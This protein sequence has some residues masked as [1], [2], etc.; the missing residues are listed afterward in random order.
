MKLDLDLD[1]G[2]EKMGELVSEIWNPRALDLVHRIISASEK[3][4]AVITGFAED[5]EGVIHAKSVRFVD[6]NIKGVKVDLT[7][8]LTV[9]SRFAIFLSESLFLDLSRTRPAMSKL[10]CSYVS[11]CGESSYG[12]A[13]YDIPTHAVAGADEEDGDST[14]WMPT[15]EQVAK[16]KAAQAQ[17]AADERMVGMPWLTVPPND[18]EVIKAPTKPHDPDD[19]WAGVREDALE[20]RKKMTPEDVAREKKYMVI[21]AG[22]DVG[23]WIV[24]RLSCVQSQGVGPKKLYGPTKKLELPKSVAEESKEDEDGW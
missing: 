4:A 19:I 14:S 2:M 15:E 23:K 20:R 6:V 22:A 13:C 12:T 3:K 21:P 10:E 7:D 18:E 11:I 9:K 17:E 16:M 1:M 5:Y 24:E 8:L